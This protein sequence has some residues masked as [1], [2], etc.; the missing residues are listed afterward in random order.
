MKYLLIF[1]LVSC[2][3]DQ[4]DSSTSS[5]ATSITCSIDVDTQKVWQSNLTNKSYDLTSCGADTN[6]RIC[7]SAFCNTF[8]D[9]DFTYYSDGSVLLDYFMVPNIIR[10]K[11]RVCDGQL[12]LYDL[13]NNNP[14]ETFKEVI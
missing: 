6:C 11:W 4:G 13:T 7:F 12:E 1:L 9:L 2:G 3:S 14:D 10:G 5:P 8:N